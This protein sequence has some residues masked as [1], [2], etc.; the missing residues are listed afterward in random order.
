MKVIGLTGGIGTG[1][2]TVSNI[3]KEKGL[4]ILDADMMSR[5]M[6]KPGGEALSEIRKHFSDSCFFEDGSLNRK[7]LS[8][9]V[10]SDKTKL[11][12]LEKITTDAVVKKIKDIIKNLEKEDFSGPVI[13][14][15]PLLIECNVHTECDEIWL[16]T[17]DLKERIKRVVARDNTDEESVLK[18]INNQLSDEDKKK[19]ATHIIDNSKDLD[20]L[21]AQI[22][23]L[24][25]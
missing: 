8:S 2:S 1:K 17:A 9:I 25:I 6:T 20:Y 4:Y 21:E 16:V 5:D 11:E 10:F 3:L 22:D 14:D 19:Y 13:I 24:L 15:A 18:R 12:E 7:A 23:K